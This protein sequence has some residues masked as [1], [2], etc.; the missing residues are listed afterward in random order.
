VGPAELDWGGEYQWRRDGEF[1]LFNPETVQKLQHATRSGQY[2]IFKEYTRGV[3]EQSKNLA[4][5]R[6]LFQLRH[7]EAPVALDAGEAVESIVRRFAT[8][9][10]SY[11]SIS[12]EAHETLAIAM[13]RIGGK[14]N[15]GEGGEDA[16]RYRRE[17]NGDWRRSAIHQVA[18]GRF[19][20]TRAYLVNCDDLQ[21]NMAPGAKPGD[22]PPLPR[23]QFQPGLAKVRR[24]PPGVAPSAP[25]P[26]HD[27]Y[28]IEDLKQL[29]HDLKN[30][31]PRARIHVKLVAEVG[32][33]TVAAGVA[34][35]FSDVVLISGHDGGTGASPLTSIK[36]GGVPWELGLAETQQVLVL[37][38]LRDRIVVQVDGQMKTGR[39]VVIAALLGA[40]EFGFSTAPLVVMGCIM[41]R[42]CHLNTCP[43]GIATQ[44]PE[45]RKRFTG[46]PEFVEQFF[47]FIA[48][49]VREIM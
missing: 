47:R 4:T 45:L 3:D 6:G 2:R 15:T 34:K 43:V 17:T 24:P 48:E 25:P 20:G 27:I 1:H 46:T 28:S 29:I 14:S 30:A 23:N 21:I 18:S 31:N 10:M 42:V 9:A 49:E 38:Q 7:A 13:N 40:E 26:H 37:N 36:H 22:G 19:G 41:M 44:D 12:Q 32:V 33:G 35:A 39:D 5:L 8:G 11:G 16:A